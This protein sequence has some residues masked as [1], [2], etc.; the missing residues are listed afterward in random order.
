MYILS[1]LALKSNNLAMEQQVSANN[2]M[3]T[4]KAPA[5]YIRRAAV[6]SFAFLIL[7]AGYMQ[8]DARPAPDSFADL[9]EKLL[10]SVVNISSTQ[11]VEVARGRRGSPDF[12]LPPGS[13]FEDFFDEF[14]GDR[15][16]ENP[17]SDSNDEAPTRRATSLGSGF[18]IDPTGY[19]VTNN[20]VIGE[21]DEIIIRMSD[22]EEYPAEIIGRDV[23]LDIALLKIEPN[24]ELPYVEFG[25]S[26]AARV[27]D[28]V[29]TIGNPFGLGGSVT[30]GIVSARHRQINS[31]PYDDYIQTDASI[32][33][34]NSG[35]PMF[36][37]GGQVIG[38]NTLIFSPTGGNVGIGFSIP[39]NRVKLVIEQLREYGKFQRGW[40]GVNIQ[41]VTKDIAESIGL[42]ESKGAIVSTVDPDGPAKLAG[43][44]PGDVIQEF[45]GIEVKRSADLPWIVAST[46]IGKEVG[47]KVF[48]DG[49]VKEFTITTKPFPEQQQ[50]IASAAPEPVAPKAEESEVLGMILASGNRQLSERF[51]IP[52]DVAGVVV[53][54]LSRTSVAAEQGIRPGDVIV[55]VNKDEVTTFGQV[56][57]QI[58]SAQE[59]GRKAVLFRVYRDGTFFHVAIPIDKAAG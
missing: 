44:E 19:I 47:V 58:D 39:A 37:M 25:D 56:Q 35:G 29:M 4:A 27:G 20:H 54:N 57:A 6:L 28:W 32:N 36:N 15:N 21:A 23:Q 34:G 45:A 55:Q 22:E 16:Q 18:V 3:Q 24:R 51:D 50:Q 9:A 8:A 49:K 53:V 38:V 14:F 42:K 52:S 13:P 7:I 1:C 33:R 41:N 2:M 10:P 5:V 43:L 48:R 26:S 46:G 11:N 40:L 12:Q 59:A 31:G 30:A 17:D